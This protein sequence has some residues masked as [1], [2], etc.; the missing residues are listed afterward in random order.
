MRTGTWWKLLA[1]NGF[2][3]DWPR[4]HIAIGV[5]V[6]TPFNDL[7]AL[8][9]SL[10]YGGKIRR[11]E[12]EKPPLF[13]LGHWRSG[14]TFL[15][16][17]L[18]T[19]P[20][21]VSP[22]TYQC[23]AANHF[24]VSETMVTRFGG[25]LLPKKRPM[26]NMEA[27]WHLPQEDEFALMNLGVPSPYLRIAFPKTQPTLLDYLALENLPRKDRQAWCDALQRFIRAL[28]VRS[29]GKRMVMKSPTH[30]GRLAELARLYPEAKFI[31]LTRDPRKLFPSTLRLW[32]SLCEV[33]A[34]HEMPDEQERK[35]Y[36]F[37]CLDT[38]YR[39]FEAAREQVAPKRIIDVRYE[40]LVADPES[41]IR[42]IYETLG[43]GDYERIAPQLSERLADHKS[44]RTNRHKMDA[45]LE[46]E[47]LQRWHDYASRYGYLEPS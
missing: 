9:Q 28:M 35:Q 31:H 10:I 6:F 25:F 27:G 26:D 38:M 33:Q 34:L 42:S 13:I 20:E 19:D 11:V 39:S 24:L 29:P 45:E 14:T 36:V 44:Y 41:T 22:T 40:D 5:S 37:D 4:M 47:I 12:L 16:E 1:S 8:T 30:T 3:V 15:H 7:L 46:A 18:V 23:F 43:L 17:L 2:R 21:C 32:N